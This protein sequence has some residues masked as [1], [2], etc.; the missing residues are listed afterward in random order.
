MNNNYYCGNNNW[1]HQSFSYPK[2][3]KRFVVL[4][5]DRRLDYA[6]I[7]FFKPKLGGILLETVSTDFA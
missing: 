5:E 2:Q 6:E 7:T 4:P 3:Q 1:N